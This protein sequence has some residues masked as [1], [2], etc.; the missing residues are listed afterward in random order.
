MPPMKGPV[1]IPIYAMDTFTPSAFPLS[2]FGKT[3][4]RIAIL[5]LKNIEAARPANPRQA[6]N[7]HPLVANAARRWA[8]R[9]SMNPVI[10]NIF[11]PMMSAS[12]PKGTSMVAFTIRYALIIY[13]SSEWDMLSSFPMEGSAIFRAEAVNVVRKDAL[14]NETSIR[15]FS[16]LGKSI[17]Q[18]S[19][20]VSI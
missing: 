3:L 12:F 17:C 18:K 1:V 14:D 5:L 11:L 13:C 15:Y 2:C 19:A 7:A 8:M 4:E 16:L 20:F 9:K 6:T 10:K